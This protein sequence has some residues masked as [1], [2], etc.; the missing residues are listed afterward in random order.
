IGGIGFAPI[1]KNGTGTFTLNG[2]NTCSGTTTVN[3]GKLVV[4]GVLPGL[5][6]M[7]SLP[8]LGGTGTVGNVTATLGHIA[9]G[10]SVGKINTGNLALNNGSSSLDVQVNGITPGTGYD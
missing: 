2:T 10:N 5:L 7:N 8:S 9:P 4:N 6:Q 1:A 3:A